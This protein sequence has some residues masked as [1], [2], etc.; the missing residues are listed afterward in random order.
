MLKNHLEVMLM[1]LNKKFGVIAVGLGLMMTLTGC[2]KPYNEP[3]FVKIEANETA[4]VLPLEGK[5]S[6]QKS[7][8]SVEYLEKNMVAAKRIQIPR[9][10]IKVGRGYW[11]VKYIDTVAVVKVD[12]SP[13]TR[14]W[15]GDMAIKSEAKDSIKFSQGISATSSILPEDTP[16]FLYMYKGKSLADIMDKEIRN[17]LETKM[18][19]AFSRKT[20]SEIRADKAGIVN[21]VSA[22]VIKYFKEYGITISN[23]GYK[24]DL[25]YAD[26]KVQDSLTAKATAQANKE[27][28]DIINKKNE[29]QAQSEL[30]Q[31][32][33]KKQAMDTLAEMKEL[34]I[35]EI[36]AK[37]LAEGK[38]KLPENLVIGENG[39]MLFNLPIK[40]KEKE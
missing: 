2:M 5:T 25:V 33:K 9:K 22:D 20:M 16:K 37:G 24:G 6:D 19:E 17:R 11:K 34:E 35:Q 26:P 15:T 12:R 38:I 28:Q 30:L 1:K 31:A 4:F 7:F 32:Q 13:E 40:G 29:E 10:E 8:E 36:L 14:E 27:A 21:E 23:I 39:N 18:I 3:K